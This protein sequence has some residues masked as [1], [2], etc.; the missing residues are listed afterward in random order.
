MGRFLGERDGMVRKRGLGPG[1]GSTTVTGKGVVGEEKRDVANVGES[2]LGRQMD[3]ERSSNS[4]THGADG[5][6]LVG[7]SEV[8][9]YPC[10]GQRHG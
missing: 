10:Q 1:E 8:V 9:L 2:E 3:G 6:E 4:S 7:W 5:G